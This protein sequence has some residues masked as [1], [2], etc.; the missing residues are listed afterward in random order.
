MTAAREDA[1]AACQRAVARI[2]AVPEVPADRTD[3]RARVA[4]LDT[5]L[6]EG[7]WT[8]LS[9]ESDLLERELASAA[10]DFRDTERTVVALLSRRDELRGLLDA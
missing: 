1:V 9:A 8:R 6:A 10:G 5:L 4:A 2:I 7:R 3:L